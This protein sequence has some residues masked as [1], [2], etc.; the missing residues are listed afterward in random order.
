MWEVIL[1]PELQRLL[2][3]TV[4]EAKASRYDNIPNKITDV[5]IYPYPNRG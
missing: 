2:R 5:I 1:R 3:E 4:I